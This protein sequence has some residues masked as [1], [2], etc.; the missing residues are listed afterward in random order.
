MINNLTLLKVEIDYS[1]YLR[2]FAVRCPFCRH[3][4]PRTKTYKTLKSLSWHI[5]NAHKTDG[6]YPF[7]TCEVREVLKIIAKCLEWGILS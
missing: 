5:T 4:T 3:C 1:Q 6:A 7:T 2:P